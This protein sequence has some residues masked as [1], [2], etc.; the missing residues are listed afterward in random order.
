[1]TAGTLQFAKTVSLYQSST[2]SWTAANLTTGSGATLAVNVGGS[3]EFTAANLDL[4]KTLSTGSSGFRP[5]SFL[6]IDTSN[7]ATGTFS[8]G[9]TISDPNGGVNRFGIAKLGA[10]TLVLSASN[11][12]SGGVRAGGG[13]L[14]AGVASAFGTGAV[15]LSSGTLDLGN[16]AISN[17]ITNMGGFVANAMSYSGTQTVAG[18]VSLTGTIGGNVQVASGGVLMGDAA[19]F[20]GAVSVLS[21]GTL[22]P[23]NSP[24]IQTFTGGL[25]L[26]GGSTIAWELAAN[27]V[28]GS[29]TTFDALLVSGGDLAIVSGALLSLTF[30]GGGSTVNWTDSFWSVSRSWTVIDHS[31]SGLSTG[32]LS[33]V[34]SESSWI[35]SSG[36]SLW[37]ANLARNRQGSSFSL[38]RAGNDIV[39][40]FT[41][42]PEPETLILV[43]LGMTCLLAAH[44]RRSTPP[45]RPE[46]IPI[47]PVSPAASTA[48]LDRSRSTNFARS[49]NRS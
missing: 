4:L 24:G 32:Q 46:G 11:T 38:A 40:N 49:T 41:A 34:G 17:P 15:T 23:G 27:T 28:L 21:G 25:S 16:F 44:R 6:G 47:R 37:D 31:G 19:R 30:N 42:V 9:S 3:G 48:G 20:S 18:A 35:D 43:G 22:A 39:L 2:A 10:G 33:L 13:T 12:F 36:L 1:V 7:A 29:G 45:C 5:G 14:R 26:S 8:Y